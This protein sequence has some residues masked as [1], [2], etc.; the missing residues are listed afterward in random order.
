MGIR[1]PNTTN[2]V[3][4]DEPNLYDLHKALEYDSE[5]RPTIR[6]KDAQAG[7]TSKNRIK[8]SDYQTSFFNTFQYGKESDVWDESTTLGGS[9]THNANLNQVV[10][11][12]GSTL[13]S[14]V[15]RQT[16]NAMRYIPGRTSTLTFALKLQTPTVGIRRRFGLF[17][18]NNGFYFEDAGVLNAD[19]SPQYNVVISSKTTGEI[20][21]T[22]VP[23]SQWNGDKLDGNGPSG[24]VADATK[25]QMV[26]FDY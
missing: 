14:K 23:R 1:N 24:I 18:E 10:M 21:E 20:V 8:I 9:A 26:V 12:V 13:G 4:N 25:Q 11:S 15:I 3:H 6:V 16:R 2:Y 19:G 7:Y 5:G 22:R 17:D